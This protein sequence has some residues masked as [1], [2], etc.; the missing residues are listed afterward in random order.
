MTVAEPAELLETRR[1]A[2]A[3]S[4]VT[5]SGGGLMLADERLGSRRNE[6]PIKRALRA[7]RRHRDEAQLTQLMAA[8]ARIDP[9]SLGSWRGS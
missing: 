7:L 6:T 1:W 2:V 3:R 9:R 8:F 5:A 4:Y